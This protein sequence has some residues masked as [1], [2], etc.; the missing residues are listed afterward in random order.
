MDSSLLADE[1]AA[2]T[3]VYSQARS[4]IDHSVAS[5]DADPDILDIVALRGLVDK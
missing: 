5:Q 2:R 4:S 3:P 1:T